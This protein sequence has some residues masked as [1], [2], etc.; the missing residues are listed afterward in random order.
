MLRAS[1][2]FG[3]FLTADLRGAQQ[4]VAWHMRTRVCAGGMTPARLPIC[5]S[6]NMDTFLLRTTVF[7]ICGWA[8]SS[9]INCSYYKCISR[10]NKNIWMVAEEWFRKKN[11]VEI[12]PLIA[13][14]HYLV[15]K[16]NHFVLFLPSL[17][18]CLMSPELDFH[19]TNC[20][21]KYK[22]LL[23]SL[24]TLANVAHSS[25]EACLLQL[26]AQT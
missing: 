14:T 6:V 2:G 15:F 24:F 20:F 3:D 11:T 8:G 16:C 12:I 17:C 19:P 7:S 22:W 21:F 13:K 26:H 23:C 1:D 4:A 10:K 9:H 18:Q 25:Y 5:L